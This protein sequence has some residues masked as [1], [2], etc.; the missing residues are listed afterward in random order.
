MSVAFAEPT[1]EAIAD[2]RRDLTIANRIL[3][4]ERVVDTFGHVSMRSPFRPDRLFM[5][6]SIA[7]ERVM[8]RDV[9]ELDLDGDPVDPNAPRSYLER[10]IHTEIYRARPDVQAVV[11]SHSVSV[12]PFSIVPDVQMRCVCHT[13]GFVGHDVPVF[14]IRDVAGEAT[15]LLVSNRE[16]GVALAEKLADKAMVLMRGHG[17][18]TVG[19]SLR[20]AVFRAVY[21]EINAQVQL[22]SLQL[23]KAIFLTEE[24]ARLATSTDAAFD[25]AWDLWSAQVC[26]VSPGP[27]A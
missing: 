15:D 10:F 22:Q 1:A 24:E 13:A 14:E 18:T 4:R 27:I 12:L 7:P 26:G 11:H 17:S 19:V 23:G 16:L 21:A 5:A 2:T 20:Q 25:R 3:A 6:R 9:V 8:Q